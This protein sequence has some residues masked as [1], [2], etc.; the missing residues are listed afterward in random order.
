MEGL[1]TLASSVVENQENDYMEATLVFDEQ[2]R[3]ASI[4][5]FTLNNQPLVPDVAVIASLN[6]V[7]TPLQQLPESMRPATLKVVFSEGGG[8]VFPG[9]NN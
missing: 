2:M 3:V 8:D 1:V 4:T 7:F 6:D 9:Y 5:D